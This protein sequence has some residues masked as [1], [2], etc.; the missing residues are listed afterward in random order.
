MEIGVFVVFSCIWTLMVSIGWVTAAATMQEMP[1]R[2][3]SI[4]LDILNREGKQKRVVIRRSTQ[5]SVDVGIV[6]FYD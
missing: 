2:Q 5:F 3:N 6:G 4:M 1:P